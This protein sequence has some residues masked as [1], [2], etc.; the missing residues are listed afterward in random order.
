MNIQKTQK[1]DI[2]AVLEIYQ[3]ARSYF[4]SNSIPQWQGDYPNEIDIDQDIKEG[5]SCIAIDHGIVIGTCFISLQNDHN[6]DYIEKG[7]WLNDNRYGV[8]HRI[9]VRS[10]YKGRGI[11][12]LFVNEA[13]KWA[14]QAGIRDLR[15][16]THER[17]A[18]MR[19]MLEKNGFKACGIIYVEDGTPRIAYQKL[20]NS[21]EK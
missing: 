2:P 9:A 14:Q 13:V 21:E 17:N 10:S 6:Y 15:A 3:D 19:R 4:K 5:G 16:D 8:I 11:A 1:K 20:L 18:S 12:D 7:K